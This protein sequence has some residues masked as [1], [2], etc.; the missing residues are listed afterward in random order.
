[1]CPLDSVLVTYGSS[2]AEKC[3]SRLTLA[4]LLV[5]P[6]HQITSH[7]IMEYVVVVIR[8]LR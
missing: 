3:N 4:L 5:V 6:A 8:H 2:G 1:M 7:Q